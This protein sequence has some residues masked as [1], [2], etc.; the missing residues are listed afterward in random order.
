MRTRDNA[1]VYVKINTKYK[2][3]KLLEAKAIED[4]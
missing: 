2:E 4:V 1:I 3:D